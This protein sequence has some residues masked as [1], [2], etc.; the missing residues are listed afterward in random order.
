M[1]LQQIYLEEKM[2]G[3]V[4]TGELSMNCRFLMER[5]PGAELNS[6]LI[7]A[8]RFIPIPQGIQH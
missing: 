3:K 2:A 6:V 5:I 1:N 8:T 4:I 7:Y